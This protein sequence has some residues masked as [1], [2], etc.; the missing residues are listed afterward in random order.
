LAEQAVEADPKSDSYLK[1]LGG[2]LY[3]AGRFE[4]AVQRLAE[5]DKLTEAPDAASKSSPAYTWYF[6]AMAHQANGQ[7]DEAKKWLGKAVEWSDKVFREDEEGTAPLAWNRRLTLRLLREEAE[8]MIEP[9]DDAG[10]GTE[11][12][13]DN[14]N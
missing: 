5:A 11:E 12:M 2:A 13:P 14:Q 10:S 8:A 9:S 4:E 1:T 6:L 3:R 7:S